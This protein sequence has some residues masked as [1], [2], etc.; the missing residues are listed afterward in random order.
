MPLA[1]N[2]SGPISLIVYNL[3]SANS[4]AATVNLGRLPAG[5]AVSRI[6]IFT[7][8]AGTGSSSPTFA[9]GITGSTAKYKAD[10]ATTVTAGWVSYTVAATATALTSADELLSMTTTGLHPTNTTYDARLVIE[11]IRVNG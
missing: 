5:Y 6:L 8:V 3:T 1:P 2:T 9:I 7:P 11:A 10:G 4:A